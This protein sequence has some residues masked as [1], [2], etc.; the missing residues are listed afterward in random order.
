M[1]SVTIWTD[2]VIAFWAPVRPVPPPSS[3]SRSK[4]RSASVNGTAGSEILT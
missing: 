2:V 3:I 1:S 4:S